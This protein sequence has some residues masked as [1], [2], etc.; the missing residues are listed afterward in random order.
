MTRVITANNFLGKL[1]PPPDQVQLET[2]HSILQPYQTPILHSHRNKILLPAFCQD[3]EENFLAVDEPNLTGFNLGYATLR[4]F[5]S[6]KI[7]ILVYW[8]IEAFY[9]LL[10]QVDANVC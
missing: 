6:E 1:P 9:E 4:L 8:Q 7:D 3:I 10:H 5:C 2:L